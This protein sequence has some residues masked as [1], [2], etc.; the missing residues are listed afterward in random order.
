[1]NL[2]VEINFIILDIIEYFMLTFE[3]KKK[4]YI[5]IYNIYR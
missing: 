1:M 4:Y 2:N 3:S 5:A